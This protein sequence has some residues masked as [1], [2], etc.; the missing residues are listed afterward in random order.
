MI[1]PLDRLRWRIALSYVSVFTVV[2]VFFGVAIYVI[3]NREID[4][5]VSR[6]LERT[7]NIQTR[8]VLER[9]RS[10]R[11]AFN[12][13]D[14]LPLERTVVVFSV[15]RKKGCP[16][17]K[18]FWSLQPISPRE[19]PN[20]I[21][22]FALNVLDDSVPTKRVRLPDGRRMALYGKSITASGKRYAA[23][24]VADVEEL[25]NRYPST[26]NGFII[27]AIVA[28]L[29]VGIGGAVLAREATRPIESAFDQ[30]RRFM[31]DAAH[32]LKTPIAVMRARTDVALQ[33]ERSPGEYEEILGA[34]SK[35]TERLGN[36]VDNMLVLA[37][38]DAGQWPIQSARVFL[39][40]IVADAAKSAEAL[41]ASKFITIKTAPIEGIAV[42]GDAT[43]L[44]Q[45]FMILLDNAVKF[46]PEGGQVTI[47]ASKRGR[48]ATVSVRDTGV[49]IPAS[50]VPHVFERFFRADPA[51]SRGGAGLG[52]S[53]ARWIVEAH[54]GRVRVESEEGTGTTVSVELPTV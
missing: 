28:M 26:V 15:T 49:G 19:A 25:D 30:M 2:M 37:R 13:N 24:A 17:C 52:L 43:L 11:T 22:Q 10:A 20:Y 39:N 23:V 35:E 12:E 34:S 5:G 4:R 16:N 42:N 9:S 8:W 54:R 27:S 1:T 41:G 36:L 51:R 18:V 33:R 3:V 45:L 44:R 6:S 21:R 50:A 32:E 47:E 48:Q 46:T 14:S 29:L 31:S 40:D 53:I 7:V 38:I